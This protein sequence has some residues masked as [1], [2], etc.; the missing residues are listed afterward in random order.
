LYTELSF[1][2]FT[3]NLKTAAI[4]AKLD[5]KSTTHLHLADLNTALAATL[6][7]LKARTKQG[8]P[9]HYVD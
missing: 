8:K 9:H 4:A 3:D 7:I 5:K 1:S 6:A 2:R